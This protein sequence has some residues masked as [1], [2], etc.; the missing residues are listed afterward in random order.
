VTLSGVLKEDGVTP[1]SGRS[2]TLKIGTQS[3]TATT[4]ASGSASCSLVVSQPLGPTT[5]TAT[6]AGDVYYLPSSESKTGLIYGTLPSGQKGA[7]VIGDKSTTGTVTFWGSQWSITNS[8]TGGSAPNAFKGF[9]VS[10]ATPS[11]GT[12]WLTDP[13]NSAPPPAGPLPAYMAVIVTSS[14]SKSGSQ[15]S[16]NTVHIVIVKTNAGYDSNP[17]HPGTG[18]VVGTIC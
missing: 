11:C 3:C 8:L 7:F 18:T 5:F 13:G 17:G 12:T 15:I 4:N 10:P 2:L 6:F 9:A 14:A 1:I 16:G